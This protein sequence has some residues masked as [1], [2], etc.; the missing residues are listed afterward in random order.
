[1][2]KFANNKKL[3]KLQDAL[4]LLTKL[5]ILSPSILDTCLHQLH[6]RLQAENVEERILVTECLCSLVSAT[7]LAKQFPNIWACLLHRAKDVDVRVRLVLVKNI[8]QALLRHEFLKT[9]ISELLRERLLDPDDRVRVE[10][11]QCICDSLF[12]N[13][14]AVTE[15]TLKDVGK[16]LLDRKSA[17]RKEAVKGLSRLYHKYVTTVLELPE[18]VQATLFLWIP[19]RVLRCTYL[20]DEPESYFIVETVL[21]KFL[22]I[23]EEQSNNEQAVTATLFMLLLLVNDNIAMN[24][25][26]KIMKSKK[27]LLISGILFSRLASFVYGTET[28]SDMKFSE[29]IS[30][31]DKQNLTNVL[32]LITKLYPEPAISFDYY[33]FYLSTLNEGKPQSALVTMKLLTVIGSELKNKNYDIQSLLEAIFK[34][35]GKHSPIL[36]KYSIL[37]ANSIAPSSLGLIFDSLVVS[38]THKNDDVLMLVSLNEL[39]KYFSLSEEFKD[40]LY[41]I[42]E[43]LHSFLTSFP[44][45]SKKLDSFE[46]CSDLCKLKVV[47]LKILSKLEEQET[48]KKLCTGYFNTTGDWISDQSCLRLEAGICLLKLLASSAK[49]FSFKDLI[50]LSF[51][52]KDECEAVRSAFIGSLYKAL[53]YKKR[54]LHYSY[55]SLFVVPYKDSPSEEAAKLLPKFVANLRAVASTQQREDGSVRPEVLLPFVIALITKEEKGVQEKCVE[56]FLSALSNRTD[57]RQASYI[58]AVTVKISEYYPNL[59]ELCNTVLKEL[60]KHA[61][62]YTIWPPPPFVDALHLPAHVFDEALE[63]ISSTQLRSL[64]VSESKRL[65]ESE[66]LS[67]QSKKEKSI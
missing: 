27:E 49:R 56:V 37:S 6:S 61:A 53:I 51:L 9:D 31:L 20:N 17:V 25:F 42:K 60:H 26:L 35:I 54:P 39:L 41:K 64:A 1:M 43:I 45:S 21:S 58:Y 29:F 44:D 4:S 3:I 57:E 11:I 15:E 65:C 36:S 62:K 59:L 50:S 13:R 34:F 48:F 14:L 24:A 19:N 30:P 5:Y 63:P 18:L 67:V 23:T 32:M 8:K 28:P 12:D 47:S 40:K 55:A 52:M 38:L 46:E 10:S 66:L 16:R 7:L 2:K 33:E 22:G